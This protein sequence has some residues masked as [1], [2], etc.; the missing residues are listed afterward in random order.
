M[1]QIQNNKLKLSKKR[2]VVNT[3]QTHQAG[4][5]SEVHSS[6]R[7]NQASA[8]IGGKEM[9][10]AQRVCTCA[11]G[12]HLCWHAAGKM[13]QQDMMLAGKGGERRTQIVKGLTS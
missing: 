3:T 10:G 8:H 6:R 7:L 12:V 2:S 1:W 9:G 11:V 5:D 4:T 13:E